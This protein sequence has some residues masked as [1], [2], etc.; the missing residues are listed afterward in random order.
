M[1]CRKFILLQSLAQ[2]ASK[3]VFRN[4]WNMTIVT[5][6]HTGAFNAYFTLELPISINSESKPSALKGMPKSFFKIDFVNQDTTKFKKAVD[7]PI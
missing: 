5:R 6:C 7:G 2:T 1:L 3:K 4:P